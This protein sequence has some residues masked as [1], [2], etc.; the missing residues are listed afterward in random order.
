MPDKIH[1][2]TNVQEG[3]PISIN[4]YSVSFSKRLPE[5]K[6][7]P[8]DLS[9]GTIYIIDIHFL[10]EESQKRQEQPGLNF[11]KLLISEFSE[12]QENLKV[13]F[14]SPLTVKFITEQKPENYI[15]N[16]LPF[17][18]INSNGDFEERLV[19][20][21][22]LW[23][24]KNSWP[25]FNNASLNLISGWALSGFKKVSTDYN[26]NRPWV[27][28]VDDEMNQWKKVYELIFDNSINLKLHNYK[29]TSTDR[30]YSFDKLQGNKALLRDAALVISD[31]YLEENH[32][33]SNWLNQEELS[34]KSGFQFY[35]DIAGTKEKA[36]KNSGVPFIVHSSSNK[37]P[38]FKF[39]QAH[40]VDD[41]CV[42][43]VNIATTTSNQLNYF[44]LFKSQVENYISSQNYKRYKNQKEIWNVIVKLHNQNKIECLWWKND[45]G[46]ILREFK[47]ASYDI[48]NYLSQEKFYLDEMGMNNEAYTA[49]SIISN[50][51]KLLEWWN[52]SLEKKQR[53]NFLYSFLSRVRNEAVHHSNSRLQIDDAILYLKILVSIFEIDSI[54]KQ[55]DLFKD[56]IA[57]SD[58]PSYFIG[59]FIGRDSTDRTGK[60]KQNIS[61]IVNFKKGL[62]I[63]YCQFY[64]AQAL[65]KYGIDKKYESEIHQLIFDLIQQ[66]ISLF[67]KN[68]IA[69][70]VNDINEHHLPQSKY[71]KF[72]NSK[73]RLDELISSNLRIGNLKVE[74]KG[75][76]IKIKNIE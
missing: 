66:K 35:K 51:Y 42:K 52:S 67:N 33:P 27:H 73:L 11:Y 39:L 41:W 28:I 44:L 43:D 53:T 2:V 69:D 70:L 16:E 36:G 38:Y 37:V 56:N 64:N 72:D 25:V 59:N 65:G 60:S 22:E 49:S 20:E 40:G 50:L 62:I 76:K 57:A 71:K 7:F 14:Y 18:Q 10:F 54:K 8:L 9:R 47:N 55:S 68:D 4:N 12:Y 15:L 74:L 61:H 1:F 3:F 63:Y 17:I 32:E 29:R 31:F 46:F 23:N 21:I 48:K 75:K 45:A 26:A 5:N 24:N 19:K 34:T 6:K 58:Y 30:K 13:I